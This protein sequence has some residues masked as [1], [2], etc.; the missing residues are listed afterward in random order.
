M[1]VSEGHLT[2]Q[3]LCDYLEQIEKT[4][5]THER[6]VLLNLF[7][8]RFSVDGGFHARV[9]SAM[10]KHPEDSALLFD[11]LKAVGS[12]PAPD[13]TLKEWLAASYAKAAE[14][15]KQI[16]SYLLRSML[17]ETN[18][19]ADMFA[20]DESGEPVSSWR[21][22]TSRYVND[23]IKCP[24]MYFG[25]GVRPFWRELPL[26]SAVAGMAG[27]SGLSP[28]RVSDAVS[29]AAAVWFSSMMV[30]E[31]LVWLNMPRVTPEEWKDIVSPLL[32]LSTPE[33]ALQTANWLYTSGNLDAA[34]DLYASITLS[35]VDTPAEKPAFEM[36]GAI[37]REFGDYDNA[38]EAYKDAYLLSKQGGA[39]ALADGLKNLCGAGV[40]VGEDMTGF[41][42]K[43]ED[44]KEKL[45]AEERLSLDFSLSMSF[46]KRRNYAEE[47]RILEQIVSD[48]ACPADIFT[49]ATSRLSSL[50]NAMDSSGLPNTEILTKADAELDAALCIDRG[51][52]A[53]LGFDP[54]CALYWYNRAVSFVPDIKR[55]LNGKLFASAVAAELL[56]E[57][58]GYTGG[59]DALEAV[60]YAM[61]SEDFGSCIG[62]LNKAV[63][64]KISQ[65][66]DAAA[67]VI[68]QV[69][70]HLTAEQRSR[71]AELVLQDKSTKF[72]ERARTALAFGTVFFDL[73]Y[74]DE[75]KAMYRAA[76]R[77]NPGPD[78]R[79]RILI[80]LAWAESECG[81]YNE[82]ITSCANA[83]K[84]NPQFPAV[85]S[86]MAKSYIRMGEFTFARE[87]A[88]KAAEL[89]PA[90]AD[91][92]HMAEALDVICENPRDAKADAYFAL[93]G[94]GNL[95]YS[96]ALYAP[97]NPAA[98]D[99]ED[100]DG[101]LA[102]R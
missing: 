101:V 13:T 5:E 33:P 59:Q 86:C 88:Q 70:L 81:S 46:R 93:P 76:L 85:F 57:A 7:L 27:V 64:A 25:A 48:E 24:D 40:D 19:I 8:H 73:G 45:T 29:C 9:V 68:Y 6:L 72:D 31:M 99:V 44:L 10:L 79:A 26:D 56:P 43:I 92:Q 36:M 12:E 11:L 47:Y 52:S 38:F 51:D 60:V 84:L 55:E 75:A 89:S 53:Y 34:L 30:E 37:L 91:Y 15:R 95:A 22:K 42:R 67:A 63:T 41:Y 66:A 4:E 21:L 3:Y 61:D 1:N 90:D 32:D 17:S 50:N 18:T 82:A 71:A 54:V 62:M 97:E 49:A 69:F 23:H 94:R 39:Y 96:A 102:F 14:P 98:W 2:Q 78:I 80:E 28:E 77:A 74:V 87:S 100:I 35:Y 16:I 83:I 65:S 20:S 58:K